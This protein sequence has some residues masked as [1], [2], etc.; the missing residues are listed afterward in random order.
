MD[1]FGKFLE[2]LNA[3]S[4]N[5]NSMLDSANGF[6]Y[7][8]YLVALLVIVGVFYSFRLGFIQIR[9]LRESLRIIT[10]KT[11][12]DSRNPER[13]TPFQS[14]MISTASRV[15]IG[16]IAGISLA[17]VVGGPGA[18]FWMWVMAF[19][20]GASAFAESTLA[21]IYKTK[22][23]KSF[24]G[25]PAYYMELALGQKWMG[26]LF[27][28]ALVLTFAYGFNG[29]QS[30]TMTSVFEVYYNTY[31]GPAQGVSGPNFYQSSW[32]LIIGL[33]LMVFAA[34]IFFS[35]SH[36]IGKVSSVIV[37]YMALIYFILSA[38]VVIVNFTSIPSV[39]G[40]I[41]SDALD[42]KSIFGGFAGSA[43]V[44]GIKRGL[45]S[46]EAGMGSA[47]NAAAS[48]HTSHPVK[49]GI[50]Q[51]TGVFLDVIICTS[52]AFLVLFSHSFT[53]KG[54]ELTAMPLIQDSMMGHYGEWGLHF[55]TV[56][57]VLFA[58]TSL[59]G[60]YYYAQINIK[61]LTKSKVFM[62]LFQFS[63]VLMVF[64]GSQIN[65]TLAWNLADFLMA[66]MATLNIIA[67]LIL[68]PILHRTLKDY[69]QQRRENKDPKFNP[70]KLGI[71]NTQ[72]WD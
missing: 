38:I 63:A 64:V 27:A 9:L 45:F 26:V 70:K 40:M 14:L 53:H 19:F 10:E 71:K 28:I 67:I 62:R 43:V 69:I 55:I 5:L 7:T 20:G 8:Y 16:N 51:S 6:M 65:L 2:G 72:C 23:G 25:G 22:D 47:P 52:S 15:G 29:L 46:N 60:N 30:Y 17:I 24:K 31:H 1:F 49:Q 33:I 18:I 59:I 35:K 36:I 56:A 50:L 61:Y 32:P 37:P 68:S 4:R 42:I 12:S 44:V 66:I 11:K 57:V 3:L 41:L 54:Q 13:I 39:L 34:F 58:I 21:Q 48:A